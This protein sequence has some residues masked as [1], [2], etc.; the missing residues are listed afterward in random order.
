MGQTAQNP[1]QAQQLEGEGFLK[2]RNPA[3]WY[4]IAPQEFEDMED[5][6][7]YFSCPV[8][9]RTYPLMDANPFTM[10]NG[11]AIGNQYESPEAEGIANR[12]WETT[13]GLTMKELGD[14]GEDVV[15]NLKVIP[16]YGPITWWSPSYNNPI[17]GGTKDHAIE[18]K[19][20]CI[21]IKN[22]RFIPGGPDRKQAMIAKAQELGYS[23]ILGV[24]VIL[25]FRTS[26]AD[27]YTMEMPVGPWVTQGNR[28]VQGPVAYRKHN[29]QQ[30]AAEVGFPN[31]FLMPQKEEPKTYAHTGDDIPF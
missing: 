6:D 23:V 9:K 22:H 19:T 5:Q 29:G 4:Y 15:Q 11:V 14:L 7:Y 17:D 18:V 21:D 10:H 8:C 31:P 27:V 16:G 26:L 1:Q 20:I 28:Q 2:C 3:C 30:L 25:D 24:L 12:N 13:V